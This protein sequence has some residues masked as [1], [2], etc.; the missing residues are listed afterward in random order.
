MLI[1]IEGI[2]HEFLFPRNMLKRDSLLTHPDVMKILL[3]QG[4]FEN[5]IRFSIIYRPADTGSVFQ[6]I[7][8]VKR[9][10]FDTG[11]F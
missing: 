3:C 1:N 2:P 10:F 4:F 9:R 11:R 6:Q 7:P 8:G 5:P